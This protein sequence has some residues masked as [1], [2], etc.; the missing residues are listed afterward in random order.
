[1]ANQRRWPKVSGEVAVVAALVVINVVLV[2]L[3]FERPMPEADDISSPGLI[4]EPV[5]MPIPS[6]SP[7]ASPSAEPSPEPEPAPSPPA[8]ALGQYVMAAVDGSTAWRMA[9]G[10]CPA[11]PAIAE[12]TVDGG[13]NWQSSDASL[14][15]GITA[16]QRLIASSADQVALIG[17][18]SDG[19]APTLVRTF[20]GGEE[21]SA[22]DNELAAAWY[23]P[24]DDRASVHAPQTGFVAAPCSSVVA[25]TA[26]SN[27]V[28]AVLCA[29]STVH[30]TVD[31]GAS[32]TG[33]VAVAGAQ[34]VTASGDGW[35]V[36][37]LGVPDCAGVAIAQLDAAAAGS[38]LVG[39]LPIEAAPADLAGRV[40]IANGAGTLWVWAGDRVA[41]SE[42]NG[43]SW[44]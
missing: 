42:S 6:S 3:L 25:I 15:T 37:V 17:Y 23:V 4:S 36:A 35:A 34:A 44:L 33:G 13:A 1:M 16:V 5:P 18:R 24:A 28:A 11:G 2:V 7:S 40:A 31:G 20:V 14:A 22:A 10:A 43:A 8:T 9:T 30:A 21:Y 41:R 19:C 27:T 32:F 38:T 39:C 12:R 26:A 29:D